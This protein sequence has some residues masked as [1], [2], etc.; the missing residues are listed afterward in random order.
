MSTYDFSADGGA[1]V[2][3]I[4]G[5]L[6]ALNVD[7]FRD[8]FIRWFNQNKQVT[9]MVVDV[10]KTDFMDSSGLGALIGMLKQFTERDGDVRIAG[11]SSNLRILFE[12][13]QAYKMFEIFDTVDEAMSAE[14]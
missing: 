3:T 11:L 9:R 5:S 2:T 1:G 10:A 13:T 4:E 7:A 12:V 8:A 6:T 14:S